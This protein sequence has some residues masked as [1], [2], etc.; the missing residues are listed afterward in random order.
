VV[1]AAIVG[2]LIALSSPAQLLGK[3]DVVSV[4]GANALS[5]PAARHLVRTPS[6]TWLLALQRDRAGSHPGLVLLRSDDD[7]RSW[8]LVDTLDG[9]PADRQTAD[10]VL[11]GEDLL[12]VRS[13][14]APS[15]VP[16]AALDPD[17]RVWFQRWRPD[18]KGG[19]EG[20]PPVLVFD[21]PPGSAF[22]RA[23]LAVDSL[24]RIWVQAFRRTAASCDPATDAKC[25]RC[26]ETQN[27]DNYSNELV[28]AVSSDGGQ[29]FSAPQSI[30]QTLCRAGG[31]LA[32]L[33]TR[34]F[35]LWNDYSAN[36]NGTRSLT[37]FSLREDT[38]DPSAWSD[39]QEA[40]PDLGADGI[41]HGAAL[42]AAPDGEGAL[43]L[44]YKDQNELRLWYR[45][46]DGRSFGPR[47]QVDDGAGDWALQPATALAGDDFYIFDNHLTATGYDTRMWQLGRGLGGDAAITLESDAAFYGYPALP[48]TLPAG[49][50]GLP[51][52]HSITPDEN[53]AGTEVALR[54]A[55][56][57]PGVALSLDADQVQSDGLP[58]TARVALAP[59]NGFSGAV[60]L[61]VS[62]AP[63]GAAVTL[64]DADLSL[65]EDEVET[66][67]SLVPGT[68]P[69]GK[70]RLVV[71]AAFGGQEVSAS[72]R[73]SIARTPPV[74]TVDE[75]V[76]VPAGRNLQLSVTAQPL[77]W[78]AGNIGLSFSG[79]PPG[80]HGESRP[81]APGGTTTLTLSAD[82]D[83]PA[84]TAS[85]A[86][87]LSAPPLTSMVAFE[88]V[89]LGAPRAEVGS[90]AEGA[91]VAGAVA[92]QLLAEVSAGT[93][94]ARVELLV[95][96]APDGSAD[97]SPAAV[98]W[99]TAAAG[100]GP[101][102]LAARVTDLAGGSS[103]SAPVEVTVRNQ[104]TVPVDDGGSFATD[105]GPAADAG[106]A[107]DAGPAGPGGSGAGD[108]APQPAAQGCTSAG[109]DPLCAAAALA[110]LLRR[111]KRGRS[112]AMTG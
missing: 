16:D 3:A 75:Q 61:A 99:D 68:A 88:V 33:G 38:D 107:V 87:M 15:I 37:R 25:A 47:T 24:G 53:Q 7:A 83:A 97:R 50:E 54:I 102:Q 96:G 108:R 64:A 28:L 35:L 39:P 52:L 49:A 78:L 9:D 73:W 32:S 92:V 36:E 30:D 60:S 86:L 93:S 45:R 21:P 34:L 81:V 51:Y 82:P 71:T 41:Y 70:Y 91:T 5:T 42:S 55:A 10:V 18:G 72:L 48:E 109:L 76:V 84:R 31:R 2:A 20:D 26:V 40:F 59:H 12:L 80:V 63:D 100:D 111:K 22:H 27:G 112:V 6:G 85:C 95:D 11:Q 69:D 13:F 44:V 58:R 43:H 89:V 101:H 94:L 1:G 29:T 90:P 19:F 79:L 105:A 74:A 57:P 77:P 62:G 14:D 8:S 23:E 46:F 17:R 103:T 66:T 104:A 106:A 67:L 4:G 98:S 65:G 56:G 110:F